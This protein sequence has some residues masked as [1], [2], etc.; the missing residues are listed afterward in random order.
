MSIDNIH[1]VANKKTMSK[2]DKQLQ[3]ATK[4]GNRAAISQWALNKKG[5]SRTIL[6]GS[7]GSGKV[8]D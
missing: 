6:F 8:T 4:R 5:P 3:A 7:S 1:N 2:I